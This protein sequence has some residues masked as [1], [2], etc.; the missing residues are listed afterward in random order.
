MA[1]LV[2]QVVV[3]DSAPGAVRACAHDLTFDM[4]YVPDDDERRHDD[5]SKRED[6]IHRTTQTQHPPT[7]TAP[8]SV[9]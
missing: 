7:R 2:V 8:Q 5:H 4:T 1:T 9:V 3:H 6:Q